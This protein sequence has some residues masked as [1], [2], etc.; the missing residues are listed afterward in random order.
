[1]DSMTTG[2]ISGHRHT[3]R[4]ALEAVIEAKAEDQRPSAPARPPAAGSRAGRSST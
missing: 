2:D 1:M 4:E 3:Y